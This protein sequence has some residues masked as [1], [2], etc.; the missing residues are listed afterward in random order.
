MDI[1]LMQHGQAFSEEADL[2]RSLTPEGESQIVASARALK[3][4]GVSLDLIVSSPK[5]RARQTAEIVAQRLG[6]PADEIK[7]TETLQPKAPS[8]DVIAFLKAYEDKKQ[9]LLAGHLPSLGEIASDLLCEDSKVA[10]QFYMGG[11]CRIDVDLLQA[12]SGTLKWILAPEHL[13]FV[14]TS[15]K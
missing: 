9:I 12:G 13:R 3:R 8:S 14:A 2:E 1:Y 15:S 7:V 11:V 4:I 10:I 6:Y 5:K